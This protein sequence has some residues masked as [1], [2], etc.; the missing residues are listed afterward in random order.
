MTTCQHCGTRFSGR[1]L[2][3]CP[4]CIKS[5][6]EDKKSWNEVAAKPFVIGFIEPRSTYVIDNY[7]KDLLGGSD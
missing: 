2:A 5:P 7:W 6:F 4:E 1:S 3:L